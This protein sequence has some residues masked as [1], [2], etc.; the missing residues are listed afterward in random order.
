MKIYHHTVVFLCPSFLCLDSLTFCVF[1]YQIKVPTKTAKI[2]EKGPAKVDAKRA[3]L[4]A[5]SK[6]GVATHCLYLKC[7]QKSD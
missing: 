7:M 4:K 5:G 3:L 1:S 2:D 6:S